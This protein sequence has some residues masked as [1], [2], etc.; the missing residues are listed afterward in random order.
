MAARMHKGGSRLLRSAQGAALTA[1]LLGSAV[2]AV[3][4]SE[5][6]GD[7][8]R[9]EEAGRDIQPDPTTTSP[10]STVAAPRGASQSITGP[11]R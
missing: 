3:V 5:G 9:R 2:V 8:S 1:G 4:V 6:R 11:P 10:A 7:R